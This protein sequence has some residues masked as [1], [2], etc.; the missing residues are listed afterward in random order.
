MS[1]R[2][3]AAT[4]SPRK[5]KGRANS[6]GNLRP[7]TQTSRRAHT[8]RRPETITSSGVQARSAAKTPSVRPAA[9][10]PIHHEALAIILACLGL[11]TLLSLMS[12]TP[13]DASLNASGSAKVSNWV[14]PVG[15][16]WGDLLLQGLGI[17]AYG[18][19]LGLLLAGWR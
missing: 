5:T 12:Y 17:G 13:R 14:G 4:K 2:R 18:L 15:A 16:Y 7:I 11:L 19:G 3:R 10:G 9:Q 1:N 6:A 8:Q